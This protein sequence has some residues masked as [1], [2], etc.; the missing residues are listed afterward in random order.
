V[1]T[2]DHTYGGRMNLVKATLRSDNSVYQQLDLD[3]GPDL[4]A[5]TA[6]DLGIET[7]LDGY[8]AEG[9]GGLHRGVSPLEL[10]RAYATFANGGNRLDISAIKRVDF[11]DGRRPVTLDAGVADEMFKDGEVYEV[12]KILQQNMKHGTGT[13]AQI[14]CPAAGKT[15]T[16][17]TFKDAWFAGYTPRMSTV[18]WVGY[19]HRSLPMTN[20]HGIKVAGATFPAQIWHDYMT[21]AKGSFCGKFSKPTERPQLEPFCGRLAVTKSCKEPGSPADELSPVAPVAT[22]GQ[23]QTSGTTEPAPVPIPNTAIAGGPPSETSARSAVFRFLAQGAASKGFQCSVDGGPFTACRSPAQFGRLAPGQHVFSVRALSAAGA[24]DSSPATYQWTVFEDLVP[25]S[26]QQ[27]QPTTTQ[28]TPK[29]K[30]TPTANPPPPV[31]SG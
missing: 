21:V 7:P 29:S 22:T 12:T 27:Q 2:Y 20:V 25:Q 26:Q 19:P 28:P 23:P 18:V 14:G 5:D 30:P 17:D 9:L 10:A 6:A 31:L 1:Q 13:A 4:V 24:P 3:V 8:P 16:T 15:G 11:V